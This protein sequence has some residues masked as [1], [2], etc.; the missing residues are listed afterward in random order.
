MQNTACI[1]CSK[2]LVEGGEFCPFFGK[3][4]AS[5]STTSAIDSYIQNKVN[6]E[7]STRLKDQSSL[8]REIGDKVEDVVWKRFTHYGVM[9]G[10]VLSC[11]LGLIAFVGIKT[12]DHVSKR[13]EPVVAAAEQRAQAAKRTIDEAASKVDSV[14]ASLDNLSQDVET[15]TKRVAEKS[16]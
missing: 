12:L 1:A 6:L 15:Q 10:V 16:W 5:S 8:V 14:K 2:P 9:A 3:K 4:V 7:L 13:I 11:I